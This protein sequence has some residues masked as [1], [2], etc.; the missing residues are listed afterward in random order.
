MDQLGIFGETN[1]EEPNG[2]A[3]LVEYG[4]QNEQSDI[5]AHVCFAI[6]RVYIFKTINGLKA[7]EDRIYKERSAYQNGIETAKGY[8]VPISDIEDI[9]EISIS[10]EDI[11][12][13]SPDINDTETDKGQKAMWIVTGL[14]KKGLFP[15]W[16]DTENADSKEMQISGID[17][18]ITCKKRIQVKCDFKGGSRILGGTG[19]LFLQ[20]KECNPYKQV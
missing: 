19:N 12:F 4:I 9:R 14:L 15:L 10:D 3:I 7:I 11:E 2:N 16:L 17:I 20:I 8:A 5:R 18:I 6:K 1:Q 13:L